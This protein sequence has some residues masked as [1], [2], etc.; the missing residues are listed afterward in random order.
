MAGNFNSRGY[1]GACEPTLE[2]GL[3][4][5]AKKFCGPENNRGKALKL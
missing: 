1:Q 5:I 3:R 4:T 2:N